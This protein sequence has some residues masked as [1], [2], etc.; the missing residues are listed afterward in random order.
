M[1]ATFKP[2][3]NIFFGDIFDARPIII[4]GIV[5]IHKAVD[6]VLGFSKPI[7]LEIVKDNFDLGFAAR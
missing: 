1:P 6:L 3:Q 2:C 5:G 4:L 7:L